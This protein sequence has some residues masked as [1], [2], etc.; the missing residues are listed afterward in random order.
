MDAIATQLINAL[1]TSRFPV[2]TVSWVRSFLSSQQLP[3]TSMTPTQLKPLIEAT[4]TR[5]LASDISA[6]GFLDPAFCNLFPLHT[7][8]SPEVADAKIPKEVFVQLMDIEDLTRSRW[9]QVEELEAIERGESKKGRE[10]VRISTEGGETTSDDSGNRDGAPSL[11]GSA[12][13]AA[14]MKSK[15]NATHRVVLQDMKGFRVFAVE[16]SRI[17]ALGVGITTIGA[18][19]LIS[20]GASIS[21]GM[22]LLEPSNCAVLG[23]GIASWQKKWLNEKKTRLKVAVSG[24]E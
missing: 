19:L 8:F 17:E 22:I 2:P 7:S 23:G 1:K 4:R 18:K 20:A 6:A 10:I 13:A 9:D 5:I 16:L 12:A 21:R 15:G 24:E 11:G 3:A 14:A